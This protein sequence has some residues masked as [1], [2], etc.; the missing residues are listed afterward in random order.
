M[1]VQITKLRALINQA[2]GQSTPEALELID[3]TLEGQVL[4]VVGKAK[5]D[6]TKRLTTDNLPLYMPNVT[7]GSA[8]TCPKCGGIREPFLKLARSIQEFTEDEAVR[9]LSG[10]KSE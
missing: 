3:K 4:A 10:M 5:A 8:P 6:G 2:G 9:M 7:N 1:I